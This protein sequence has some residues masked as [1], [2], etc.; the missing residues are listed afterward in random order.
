CMKVTGTGWKTG[1]EYTKKFQAGATELNKSMEGGGTVSGTVKEVVTDKPLSGVNIS[2]RSK[3]CYGG[4]SNCEAYK[5][6]TSGGTFTFS[7]SSHTNYYP[8]DILLNKTNYFA[9]EYNNTIYPGNTS[10]AYHMI[11]LG[12]SILNL[13]VTGS[14]LTKNVTIKWGSD[15]YDSEH[16]YCSI[17]GNVLSCLLPSG[18]R[19]LTINGS[20]LGYGVYSQ[21]T[22]LTQGQNYTKNIKLNETN[23]NIT[24]VNQDGSALDNITVTMDGYENV[25]Q[26][27]SVVF[28]RVP[29]GSYNVTFS[30]DLADIYGFGSQ[31]VQIDVTPGENNTY[32]YTFN[33][34][35]F[36]AVVRNESSLGLPGLTVYMYN[37]NNS[38]QNI[39]SDS[40]QV[41]FR[42]VPYGNYNIS[43]NSTELVALGYQDKNETVEAVLGQDGSSGNN[44]T[45]ILKDT[46]VLFNITNSSYDP[47]QNINVSMLQSGLIARNG[48]DVYL[49]NLSDSG[50]LVLFHNVIPGSYTYIV[51]G[52]SQGYEILQESLTVTTSGVNVSKILQNYTTTTTTTT[53]STTA[54]T[55]TTLYDGNG[56]GGGGGGASSARVEISEDKVEISYLS[57]SSGSSK[58]IDIG[59]WNGTVYSITVY[60]SQSIYRAKITIE[61]FEP[62]EI[63]EVPRLSDREVYYYLKIDTEG[64]EGRTKNIVLHFSVERDWIEDKSIG[65]VS[66][67]KYDSGWNEL[68]TEKIETEASEIK[69]KSNF[70]EFSY[71]AIAGGAAEALT[72]TT[73]IPVEGPEDETVCGNG[74]CESGETEENCPGDCIQLLPTGFKLDLNMLILLI[75]LLVAVLIVIFYLKERKKEPEPVELPPPPDPFTK[76]REIVDSPQDYMGKGVMIKGEILSSEFLPKENRVK[77]RIKDETGEISGLSRHAGYEGV[78]TIEGIVR[79]K[80]GDLYVEF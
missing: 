78:G 30:G 1:F 27:G 48:Y 7:V 79:Q 25:T 65:K 17:S 37:E 20:E 32:Q 51:N 33:E 75:I 70:Q 53:T 63:W 40:G 68:E 74:I 8:Y 3:T 60:A 34:T 69:Y 71:F 31:T 50:G 5:K 77:Y 39:T 6:S 21:Y 2:L 15:V 46:E 28:N 62:W 19:V 44:K 80:K 22:F 42:Q 10:L 41:L 14:T 24:V 36:L 72:T 67:W 23:V 47:L 55:T 45:I 9:L 4:Y 54:T 26:N 11:P 73:T 59:E 66:L 43:F 57:I 56:G 52:S 18:G 58:T 38:F 64:L 49:T 76:V 16:E 12:R 29:G 35:Q 61:M 13:N